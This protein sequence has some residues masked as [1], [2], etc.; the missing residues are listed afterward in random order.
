MS[1]YNYRKYGNI[2]LIVYRLLYYYIILEDGARG[3]GDC[4]PGCMCI[5]PLVVH[6]A[7]LTALV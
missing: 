1:A 3:Q 7:S 6:V 5:A 2:W 4:C